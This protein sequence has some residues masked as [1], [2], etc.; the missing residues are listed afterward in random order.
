[1]SLDFTKGGDPEP[2][3]QE[4]VLFHRFSSIEEESEPFRLKAL[5]FEWSPDCTECR[6]DSIEVDIPRLN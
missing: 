1:M 6:A 4:R 2:K 3:W 5:Q